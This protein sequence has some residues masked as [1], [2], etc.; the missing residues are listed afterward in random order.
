[1]EG[2]DLFARMT[3]V[4]AP[5]GF[6]ERVLAGLPA[7]R[8]KR[9]RARRSAARYAFAGS[10]ALVLAGFFLFRPSLPEKDAVLT[11]AERQALT[12]APGKGTGGSADRRRLVPV[13]ETMDYASE[14]RNAQS[15]PA[16]IYI[17]EQVSEIPSSEIIY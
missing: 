4:E 7:A 12:A 16:T 15:Q 3:K 10:A 14:F 2:H 17:L 9:A 5:A 6:E 11:V 13:Y 8:E 1:M